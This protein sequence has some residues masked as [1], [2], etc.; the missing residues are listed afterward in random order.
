MASFG[1]NDSTIFNWIPKKGGLYKLTA[2][3]NETNSIP[4]M[5]NSDNE[6]SASFAVYDLGEPSIVKPIDG[7]ANSNNSVDFLFVDNGYYLNLNLTYFIEID[8]SLNFNN[9][10]IKFRCNPANR[11]IVKMEISY[12]IKWYLFLENKNL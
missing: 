12:I 10:I 5:D 11:W 4:E 8:T 6:A 9:P 7:L 1:E 2:K 3:I